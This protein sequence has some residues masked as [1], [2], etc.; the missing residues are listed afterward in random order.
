VV[1]P[2]GNAREVQC[3]SDFGIRPRDSVAKR[4]VH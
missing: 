4:S 1:L 2:A 3:L